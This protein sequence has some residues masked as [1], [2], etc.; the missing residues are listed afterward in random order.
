MTQKTLCNID[1]NQLMT[2]LYHCEWAQGRSQWGAAGANAPAKLS[3]APENFL[4]VNA[5]SPQRIF[6]VYVRGLLQPAALF[7]SVS[8][9]QLRPIPHPGRPMEQDV[10]QINSQW[11]P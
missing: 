8:S 6:L 2:K 5:E 4:P 1:S 10:A 7:G 3:R 9:P 11:G